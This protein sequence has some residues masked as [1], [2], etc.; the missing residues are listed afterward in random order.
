MP[1]KHDIFKITNKANISKS[2]SAKLYRWPMRSTLMWAQ[3]RLPR[4]S[5][6]AASRSLS[7]SAPGGPSAS[8]RCPDAVW[9]RISWSRAQRVPPRWSVC[10][11]FRGHRLMWQPLMMWSAEP[12][13][14]VSIAYSRLVSLPLDRK[15]LPEEWNENQPEM[16]WQRTIH[17]WHFNLG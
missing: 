10:D 4:Q 7:S 1:C 16:E 3:Q 8:H 11:H 14:G 5:A 12:S 2:C 9:G 17:G 6:P 15:R 13:D